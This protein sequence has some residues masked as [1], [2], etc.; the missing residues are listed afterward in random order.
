MG[1]Y[2]RI[3]GRGG[4][5]KRRRGLG[6]GGGRKRVGASSV[7]SMLLHVVL[8]SSGWRVEDGE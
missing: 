2:V 7:S 6:L 1:I 4:G 8:L 3:G 5:R